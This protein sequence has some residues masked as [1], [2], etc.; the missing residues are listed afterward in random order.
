MNIHK[1]LNARNK[2]KITKE[3]VE[4]LEKDIYCLWDKV[5][6][7]EKSMQVRRGSYESK[8]SKNSENM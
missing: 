6:A 3:K 1:E 5:L 8:Q 2:G 4:V 7:Y